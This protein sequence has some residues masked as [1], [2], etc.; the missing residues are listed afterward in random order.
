MKKNSLIIIIIALLISTISAGTFDVRSYGGFN[1]LQLSSDQGESIIDGIT[2]HRTVSGRPGMQFGS[3]VTFGDRFYI[4]P[5]FQ[6]SILSTEII[7]KNS[8]TQI[9]D[10]TTLNVI[11]IPLKVGFR[12]IDPK[13]EDFLNI[14]VFVGIDGHHV[15]SVDHSKKSGDIDDI[16]TE[17]YSNLI[18][19]ADFGFGI[20][21]LFLYLETGYQFGLSPVH[22]GDD[23]AKANSFYT[24]IGIKFNL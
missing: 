10:K 1:M 18:L 19:N 11:S 9:T 14:R 3:A 21:I 5:G 16:T 12:L 23:S 17:D 8:S 15:I 2:H 24:N 20:D 13:V 4:Q 7:N 22:S 6:Y